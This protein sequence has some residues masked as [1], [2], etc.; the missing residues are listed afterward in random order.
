MDKNKNKKSYLVLLTPL[1]F[2]KKKKKR[3]TYG[4]FEVEFF[5]R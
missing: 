2:Y 4:I 3:L 5:V 1:L